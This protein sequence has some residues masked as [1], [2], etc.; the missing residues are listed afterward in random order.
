M[1]NPVSTIQP[2][3]MP[4]S[5]PSAETGAGDFAEMLSS[6]IQHLGKLHNDAVTAADQFI[7]GENEDVHT[8][9]LAVQKSELAFE[10]GLQIRSKVI[11]AYQEVMKMQL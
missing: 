1:I 4:A 7:T 8:A 3:P 2:I 10:L 6:S 5:S 9:A 11:G